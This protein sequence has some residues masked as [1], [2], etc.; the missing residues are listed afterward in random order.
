MDNQDFSIKDVNSD[1]R[2][3]YTI[4]RTSVPKQY[5]DSVL[6]GEFEEDKKLLEEINGATIEASYFKP[7]VYRYQCMFCKYVHK[8]QRFFYGVS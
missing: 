6:Y 1:L 7:Q 8:I 3:L 2:I 5:L 4:A